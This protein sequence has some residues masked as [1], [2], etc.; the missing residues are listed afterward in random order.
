M[1]DR[2][3]AYDENDVRRVRKN[4]EVHLEVTHVKKMVFS[5]PCP[6]SLYVVFVPDVWFCIN[7]RIIDYQRMN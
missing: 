3:L 5:S 7:N 6:S 2:V 1:Y 4:I